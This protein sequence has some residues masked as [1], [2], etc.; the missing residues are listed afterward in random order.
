MAKTLLDVSQKKDGTLRQQ[1]SCFVY[2]DHFE[3]KIRD[4]RFC[5]NTSTRKKG[6]RFSLI[7]PL[8]QLSNSWL[9]RCHTLSHLIYILPYKTFPAGI[10][11]LK[12]YNVLFLPLNDE[13]T[14][15]NIRVFII[16][17][18]YSSR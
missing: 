2:I 1:S 4:T 12:I 7:D 17:M 14:D 8:L 18:Y 6:N 11:D 10:K 16:Y 13:N 15:K 3:N 5:T 9:H